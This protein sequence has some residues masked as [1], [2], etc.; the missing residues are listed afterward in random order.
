MNNLREK[1]FLI[2]DTLKKNSVEPKND[3][4][5]RIGLLVRI[6]HLKKGMSCHMSV[7]EPDRLPNGKYVMTSY[8]EEIRFIDDNV[9]EIE[10]ENTRYRL[11]EVRSMD[12][13][14]LKSR[15]NG[16][17]E[18]LVVMADSVCDNIQ[19]EAYDMA[20]QEIMELWNLISR[21]NTCV[22]EVIDVSEEYDE[23]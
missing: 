13:D 12:I 2:T 3:A 16:L 23:Y 6:M 5:H 21:L 8:V 7:I 19:R 14:T 9:I 1:V 15:A 10:T 22:E 17:S 20:W 11:M 4:V 18:D